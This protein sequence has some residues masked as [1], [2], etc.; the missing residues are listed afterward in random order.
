MIILIIIIFII[1]NNY[2]NCETISNTSL[3]LSSY[4]SYCNHHHHI[5]G[6]W[7]KSNQTKKSFYC[8][9]WDNN[10]YLN[11]ND[12]CEQS[13]NNDI[14]FFQGNTKYSSQSGA[15][16]CT[17]DAEGSRI[18]PNEREN[19]EWVSNNCTMVNVILIYII[20]YYIIYIY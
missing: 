16:S 1:S 9:S 3:S 10:D 11:M 14:N 20:L 13:I 6:T 18:N 15:H 8:C 2:I 19:Y 7:I 17:C 5:N 12:Y 4:Q